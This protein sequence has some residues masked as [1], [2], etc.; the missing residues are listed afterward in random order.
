MAQITHI[1]FDLHGTLIDGV[2]L[3][4]CYRMG[5]GRHMAEWYGGDVLKWAEANTR[6]MQ[7]WDSYYADLDLGGDEGLAHMW[8]GLFRT[9]RALFRLTN[10]PEPAHAEL[11][12]LSRELPTISIQGCD[13]FYADT[14]PILKQL[15]ELGY[16]LNVTSHALMEGGRGLLNGGGMLSYFEGVFIGPD[17]TEQFEKDEQFYRIALMKAGISAENA[18]L[19]DDN[20]LAITCA[21]RLG[22]RTVQIRRTAHNTQNS[23]AD[24]VLTGDLSGL[25]AY[26]SG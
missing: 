17:I 19:V 3:H 18:M 1:F 11:V 26:L 7:D 15:Y 24:L 6:I 4:E 25:I 23:P 20:A 9:T 21:Q 10:T 5:L 8:E 16:I 13:A 2:V 14:K 22:M 12:R